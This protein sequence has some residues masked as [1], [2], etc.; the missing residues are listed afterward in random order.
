VARLRERPLAQAAGA[1][2]AAGE[3]GGERETARRAAAELLGQV[4]GQALYG[5]EDLGRLDDGLGEG[6][7]AADRGRLLEGPEGGAARTVHVGEQGVALLAQVRGDLGLRPRG[8][9]ADGGEAEPRQAG[10]VAVRQAH[11]AQEAERQAGEESLDVV[12]PPC[13]AGP[14]AEGGELRGLAVGRQADAHAVGDRERLGLVGLEP[15]QRPAA[16]AA[17]DPG[18]VAAQLA[19]QLL[20]RVL[21]VGL[22]VGDHLQALHAHA[23][24]VEPHARRYAVPLGRGVGVRDA[25]LLD[26]DQRRPGQLRVGPHRQEQRQ[27]VEAEG[28]DHEPLLPERLECRRWGGRP[29]GGRPGRGGVPGDWVGL[30]ALLA[31][32]SMRAT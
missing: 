21:E 2:R 23:R 32:V 20:P 22:G 26:A 1:A 15:G 6:E 29:T 12:D 13:R 16:R 24:S 10:E 31:G 7:R 19:Q 28:G 25:L 8:Q 4:V 27:R 17:L 3:A 18:R 14:C 9:V 11:A 30:V 5:G